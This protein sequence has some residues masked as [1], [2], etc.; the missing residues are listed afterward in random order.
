MKRLAICLAALGVGALVGS[1]AKAGSY[2]YE[3]PMLPG[4]AVP[5]SV[6]TRFGTLHFFGGFPDPASVDKLYDNLDFQRAVPAYL[7]AL[8]VV[9]QVANRDA[10]LTIG[11]ANVTVPI[12]ESM[13]NS[14]T[15]ELTANDNTPYTW[16][17]VDLRGGP[18]VVEAPPK[19]LGAVDDM[20]YKWIGDVGVTGPDRGRGGKY[21]LLPPG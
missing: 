4:V 9:S 11:P 3:T 13:V 17:W 20:W 7:L 19:V 1:S 18:L 21:L 16:L 5:D 14:R 2:K 8:P 6:E 12:W 15:T 10:T